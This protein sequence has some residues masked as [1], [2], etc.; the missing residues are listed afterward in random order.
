M[1]MYLLFW[2]LMVA[3]AQRPVSGPL[4]DP[5]FAFFM[6]SLIPESVG[7]FLQFLGTG[8]FLA[9][10]FALCYIYKG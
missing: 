8:H 6:L 1:H 2:K 7:A 3:G 9:L 10:S 4:E 5:L